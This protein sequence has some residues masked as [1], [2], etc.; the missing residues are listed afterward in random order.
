MDFLVVPYDAVLNDRVLDDAVVADGYVGADGAVLDDH[1]VADVARDLVAGLG[2]ELDN[3]INKVVNLSAVLRLSHG[4]VNARW[5][6]HNFWW[7]VE[8]GVWSEI[9]I[10]P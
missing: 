10:C 6:I 4:L 8:C 7:S 5:E 3:L 9:T 1:V 2:H